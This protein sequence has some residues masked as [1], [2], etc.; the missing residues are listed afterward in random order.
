MKFTFEVEEEETPVQPEQPEE[1]IPDNVKIVDT[2]Y[3]EKG[4]LDLTNSGID[5][6]KVTEVTVNGSTVS[7]TA[8][9]NVLTVAAGANGTEAAY[10][11]TTPTAIYTLNVFACDQAIATADEFTAWVANPA[12]YVVLANNVDMK[13]A[14][15]GA[16][17]NMG[18][19]FDGRGYA[20]Y[21]I[22]ITE[23]A[24]MFKYVGGTFKNVQLINLVQ[25]CTGAT[26]AVTKG[27]FGDNGWGT[28]ENILIEA[29]I[30]NIGENHHYGFLCLYDA[31]MK[32]KNIVVYVESDGTGWHCGLPSGASGSPYAENVCFVSSTGFDLTFNSNANAT[33]IN[34]KT[35]GSEAAMLEAVD[36]SE[37]G[38][39]WATDA[40]GAPCMREISAQAIVL[41]NSLSAEII[42]GEVSLNL[43][44]MGVRGTAVTKVT[45]G[46]A[47][48]AYTLNENTLTLNVAKQ[49]NYQLAVYTKFAI[50]FVNVFCYD[51]ETIELDEAF[52]A[53]N[54]QGNAL[55]DL[56]A[57]GVNAASVTQVLCNGASI[58]FGVEGNSLV[59][60]GAPYGD[61]TYVLM[62][63]GQYRY[64]V[65][66]CVYDSAI[67]NAEEF[68]AWRGNAA[69]TPKGY[70]VLLNDV[71]M[72]GAVLSAGSEIGN[73]IVSTLDGRGYKVSNF[74][75]GAGLSRGINGGTVKNIYFDNVTQDCTGLANGHGFFGNY[76]YNATIENVYFDITTTN[77]T[78]VHYGILFRSAINTPSTVKNVVLELDNKDNKFSYA[79]SGGNVAGCVFEG[80]VGAQCKYEN[81]QPN[82]NLGVAASEGNGEYAPWAHAGGFAEKIDWMIANEAKDEILLFTSPYWAIDTV[83]RTIEM[84]PL[85][86]SK[87]A[88]VE[89]GYLVKEGV[90]AYGIVVDSNA[91]NA[92]RTAATELVT[93][94]KEA[95]G[96]ELRI[97][98]DDSV[99]YALNAKYISL[100]AND[101]TTQSGVKVAEEE[102]GAQGYKI[103]TKGQNIVIVGQSQGVLYGVY[104]LMSQ[105]F[106]FEQYTK[107]IYT[108]NKMD[109]AELPN[110]N[111]IDKPDVEHRIAFSGAQ[112]NDETARNRMRTQAEGE[113]IIEYGRSHNMI[114]YIVPF[115]T[116]Y[117]TNPTWYSNKTDGNDTYE[118]TQ[119]CYTA[120][121]YGSVNYNA[122]KAVAVATIKDII[123][124]NPNVETLSLT[125]M[126]V[127][128]MWCNCAGCKA[129]IN[130]YGAN[131]ATQVLFLNDVVTEVNAWLDAEKGGKDVQFLM[132]A[133]YETEDAPTGLTLHEDISV[134]IAPLEGYRTS[135]AQGLAST[136]ALIAEWEGVAD[137]VAVWAYGVYFSEYLVPYNNFDQIV[138]LI[139]VSA[140]ANANWM[141]IQGNWNTTQNTG[142][143]SLKSYLI[144]K[145]MWDSSLNV[146]TLT[147]NF[148]NAVYGAAAETMKTVYTEMK[149]QM[150]S[151][152]VSGNVYDAPCGFGDWNN[153]YLTNQL[154]RLES[155]ANSV[156]KGS[157]AYD[158][159]ICESI[160][161]R[162]IYKENRSFFGSGSDYSS[163]AW[164]T[165]AEDVTRLGFTMLSEHTSMDSYL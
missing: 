1:V 119:L 94:F 143:D 160:S 88:K 141:W 3:N 39:P 102:V 106:G 118:S 74:T 156:T 19:T 84:K 136:K 131:S 29:K 144:S 161:F 120:G 34:C 153:T 47:N 89:D 100:G 45:L 145:L 37:W 79:Y 73:H 142:F 81:G 77:L 117:K 32:Y 138:E 25:D 5:V 133:Y 165:F 115:D 103:A 17:K 13:G 27:I 16:G 33:V 96:V 135:A 140:D 164:G 148:F 110:F 48:V 68:L 22:T 80:I 26:S 66:G 40:N 123:T 149:K 122:M 91:D 36:F 105:L 24:G 72:N 104:E 7:F 87:P 55:V 154:K 14:I 11:I 95:T 30:K 93:L 116:Y 129:V 59:L 159:I 67:T 54:V 64:I 101:Y 137:S 90:S 111:I 132:L 70:Y 134:W 163:S 151:M 41:E 65:E 50:Y 63:N 2:Y 46:G 86:A 58:S 15:V 146:E 139:K 92:T 124:Q 31:D 69:G 128:N 157:A 12:G 121:G 71:D 43:A 49:G 114:R 155:A 75:Y 8:N 125:Q 61:Q 53:Q 20:I 23:E 158:A 62:T 113:V 109:T 108:L 10:V 51:L 83:A 18:G 85:A 112:R 57:Y 9:G 107:E 56:S 98:S 150:T 99:D 35:Y 127:R 6:S 76:I 130:Q 126:D 78:G 162:Y 4:S 42:G 52:L 60:T 82:Y 44:A 28:I 38:T 97:V 152:N 147:D 21:N